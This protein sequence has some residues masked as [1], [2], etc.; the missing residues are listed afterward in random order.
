MEQYTIGIDVG[1]TKTAYGVLDGRKNI[2]ARLNHPSDASCSPGAFFDRI[3]ANI[4]DLMAANRLQQGDVRG[5]GVGV[6]SF[7]LFEEGRIIKTSNLA[8]LRDFPARAYLSEKLG[9]IRVILD[10][11]AHAAALAEHRLGAGRG[12]DNLLYC[13]VSTGVSSAVIID[14]RIFRGSYGWSGESGHMIMTPDDGV[15]CGCGNRGCVMSW[16][17]GSMIAKHVK[18]WIDAGE[19]SCIPEF[20]GGGEISCLHIEQAYNAGDALARRAVAQM[21]KY[22]GVWTYNLYVT[23][24]IN[25]FI[26]GGGLLKMWR[27][28]KDNGKGGNLLESMKDVFDRYN[29]NSM[30]VYFKEAELGDDFGVIGAAELLF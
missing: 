13:P 10:N 8:N 21:I 2:V 18:N 4:R 16:C 9:G 22:L 15:E 29:K 26:F 24:N 5:I 17:S 1:G 6:P 30:P 25:C 19:K 20:A 27:N 12:F 28:L 3:A 14:G 23:F 7:V 11:D